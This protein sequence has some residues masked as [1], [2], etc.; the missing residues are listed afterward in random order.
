M[1]TS[2]NG[3]IFRVTGPLW[4]EP[5]VTGVFSPQRAATRSF[6]VF[7]D[8]RL[9]TQISKQS[10]CWWFETPSR[11][12][13]RYRKDVT[14]IRLCLYIPHID[15]KVVWRQIAR[16]PTWLIWGDTTRALN[17]FVIHINMTLASTSKQHYSDV[18]MG[19]IESQITSLTIVYLAVYSGADQ[20]KHQSST[21][22]AF[23]RGI[24]R[25]PVI[26]P[27]KGPVTRKV[28]PFDD[29]IMSDSPHMSYHS[30]DVYDT[31][32]WH[33]VYDTMFMTL[34]ALYRPIPF[35]KRQ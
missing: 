25:S 8:L 2:A 9:N 23:V 15:I 29:V 1:V 19:T 21:L 4:G 22:L 14:D 35:K 28:F 16:N 6:D 3:N 30:H 10:K 24:H 34:L 26:S 11:S 17:M 20:R 31:M 7:I 13:W 32:L 18:I 5:P 12:S 33:Y 27:H